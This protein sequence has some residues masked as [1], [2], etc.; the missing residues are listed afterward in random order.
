MQFTLATLAALA[1]ASIVSA[2]S[3]AGSPPPGCSTTYAGTFEITVS[4][5]MKKRDIEAVS[6]ENLT[7]LVA[8]D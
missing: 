7:S 8:R 5:P 3:S 6:R 1:V 2:Q 4:L